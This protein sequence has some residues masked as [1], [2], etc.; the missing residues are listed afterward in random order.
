MAFDNRGAR[1]LQ[2]S[3]AIRNPVAAMRPMR[4]RPPF[5]SRSIQP[6][7]ASASAL[8]SFPATDA[9]VLGDVT[10][11]TL[12]FGALL[13]VGG[14]LADRLGR[15]RPA[16]FGRCIAVLGTIPLVFLAELGVAVALGILLDTLVVRSVLVT[17]LNL[18][19]GP[20]IWWPRI[21]P[22]DKELELAPPTEHAP[23]GALVDP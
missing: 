21:L 23:A 9:E 10:A 17:A 14:R 2:D 19:L 4:T 3:S 22:K 12:A 7:S 18:D 11:Y 6:S 16:V 15:R 1:W 8:P 5:C 13:L 20:V